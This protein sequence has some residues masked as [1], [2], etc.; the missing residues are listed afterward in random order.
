LPKVECR[1]LS[2]DFALLTKDFA[3][4][5]ASETRDTLQ[6]LDRRLAELRGYL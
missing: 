2:F 1:S 4:M 5:L 3:A 6:D